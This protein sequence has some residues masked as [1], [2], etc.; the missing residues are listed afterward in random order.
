MKK[1]HLTLDDDLIRE[2]DVIVKKMETSRSEFTRMALQ[3]A[4]HKIKERELEKKHK[5]GY[6]KYPVTKNEFGVWENE[7]S[8]A[9]K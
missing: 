5:E 3:D 9:D 1:I 4:I 7:Q 6:K 2:V 8:W